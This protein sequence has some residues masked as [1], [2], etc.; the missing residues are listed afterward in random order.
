MALL[1]TPKDPNEIDDYDLIWTLRLAGDVILTSAW[2]L[3]A[4]VS[5][6]IVSNSFLSSVTSSIT[7]VLLSGGLLNQTYRFKNTITT[8]A[9][10]TLDESVD[11]PIR[12]K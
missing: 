5:I 6:T 10:N 7:K 12:W 4:G 9:G 3:P 1:W 2:T 11:L 8:A